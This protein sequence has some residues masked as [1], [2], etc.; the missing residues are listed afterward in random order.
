M[1]HEEKASNPKDMVGSTK[2]M[3]GLVPDT[4]SVEASLAYMEGMLK[5]GRANWRIA[6]VRASIYHDALRR[7]LAK[8]WNGE[9]ADPKTGVKHLASIIACAGILLDAELCDQ[10]TDDRPP[11]SPISDLIDEAEKTMAHLVEMFKD[12]NPKHYSIDDK[13]LSSYTKKTPLPG[14]LIDTAK[15]FIKDPVAFFGTSGRQSISVTE[16][17]VNHLIEHEIKIGDRV[18][19][20]LEEETFCSGRFIE[21]APLPPGTYWGKVISIAEPSG[22][23]GVRSLA[24]LWEVDVFPSVITVSN[25][26]SNH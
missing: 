18:R 16:N 11:A 17:D 13:P 26:V 14:H 6:G 15:Y 8:W 7:H 21:S 25:H 3:M 9:V 2:L 20:N 5:Y 12:H 19:L 4:I 23:I 22:T 24:S 1:S 10:L